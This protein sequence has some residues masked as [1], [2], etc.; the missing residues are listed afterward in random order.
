MNRCPLR[1]LVLSRRVHFQVRAEAAE[2]TSRLHSRLN[3]DRL[4]RSGRGK[5]DGSAALGASHY[6]E[7]AELVGCLFAF[8][9]FSAWK[10]VSMGHE[11]SHCLNT[12]D[13]CFELP[14]NFHPKSSKLLKTSDENSWSVRGFK[15]DDVSPMVMTPGF[16]LGL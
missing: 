1:A 6:N 15:R 2:E 9:E 5:S 4:F 8:V 14:K 7:S 12:S 10:G 3:D 11:I 16:H 13:F